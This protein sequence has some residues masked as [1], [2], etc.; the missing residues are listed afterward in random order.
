MPIRRGGGSG[1]AELTRLISTKVMIGYPSSNPKKFSLCFLTMSAIDE[2]CRRK[3]TK[4]FDNTYNI[5][6]KV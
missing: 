4:R 5:N 3:V 6:A 1:G 2:K